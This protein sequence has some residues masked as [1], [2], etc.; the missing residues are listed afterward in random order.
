MSKAHA[1]QQSTPVSV[2]LSESYCM[3]EQEI[4]SKID[5]ISVTADVSFVLV[6]YSDVCVIF[7]A[8][9]QN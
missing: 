2:V 1:E 3:Q 5:E 6:I 8:L 9:E 7:M 4:S